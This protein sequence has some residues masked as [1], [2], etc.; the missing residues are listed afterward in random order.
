M[1]FEFSRR[2]S[3]PNPDLAIPRQARGVD[4]RQPYPGTT[5]IA[6]IQLHPRPPKCLR[7]Q[8]SMGLASPKTH[9][10]KSLLLQA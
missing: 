8:A 10:R 4:H 7:I 1:I 6:Q 9:L 5:L 2:G 3:V